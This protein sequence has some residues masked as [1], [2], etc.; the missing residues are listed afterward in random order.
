MLSIPS[1][2]LRLALGLFILQSLSYMIVSLSIDI[3]Q[4]HLDI[5]GR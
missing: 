2:L 3:L 4:S 1:I 5:E